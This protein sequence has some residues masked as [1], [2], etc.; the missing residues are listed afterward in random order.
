[1]KQKNKLETLII[2]YKLSYKRFNIFLIFMNILYILDFYKP[3]K[4]WIE[5]LFEQIIDHF[6]KK[7][8]ISIITWNYTQQLKNIEKQWNI[9]IYRIKAKNLISYS[10]KAYFFA[11]KII[12]DIDIIHT[13]NFYSAFV[14]SRLSKK[15]K[16]KS[17]LH[18]NW[19]FGNY[20]FK[21]IDKIRAYKFK[22][23]EYWNI[24]WNFD[25]YIVVSRYIYDV[26]Y[27]YYWIDNK[28]LKLVYNGIDYKKWVNNINEEK[29][30]QI[31]KKYNLK[32]TY[33]LLFY[34]RIEKVKWINLL[35]ESIQ[36]IDNIKLLLIVHWDLES[37]KHN[38][39]QLWIKDKTIVIEWKEHNKIANFIKAVNAV[40]F[41]S[42]TES[43]GYVWLETSILGTPLICSNI[44][45]IP[46]VVFWKVNFF[47]V[48]DKKCLI[49]VIE[50][51]KKWDFE[52]IPYKDLNINYTLTN[53][54]E[55]YNELSEK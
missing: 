18:I 43:F 52:Q 30:K 53:I 40:V 27:F 24:K 15:Y 48:N 44:W 22:L 14:A 5:I 39:T 1:M 34:G 26:A 31:Q 2:K 13:S 54:K 25:K 10:I 21:M 45:A 51:S 17:I 29:V 32:Q 41:P 37:L 19:F 16:K 55:V 36:K 12:K 8:K 23:L 3:N 46:E 9:T 20:R 50:K 42:L 28:K 6:W 38:I 33:S 4:W 47:N 35:L 11:K 49:N 7:H